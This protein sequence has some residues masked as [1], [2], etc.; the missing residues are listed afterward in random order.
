MPNSQIS[1]FLPA[2]PNS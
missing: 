1:H 2:K